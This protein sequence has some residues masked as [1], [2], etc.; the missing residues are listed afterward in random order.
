MNWQGRT[1]SWGQEFTVRLDDCSTMQV[2]SGKTGDLTGT[3]V[4]SNKPI[5]VFSGNARTNVKGE[6]CPGCVWY[7]RD[8]LVEQLPPKESWAKKFVTCPIPDR[9]TGKSTTLLKM[10]N[11]QF[12]I[13]VCYQGVWIAGRTFEII[14]TRLRAFGFLLQVMSTTLL[15]VKTVPELPSRVNTTI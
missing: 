4:K 2:Q 7:T 15:L 12:R 11:E 5:A 13:S 14:Q 10:V 6:S 9:T 1:Y 8:H 3:F